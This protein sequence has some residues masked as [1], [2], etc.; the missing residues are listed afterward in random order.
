MLIG[1]FIYQRPPP[2]FMLDKEEVRQRASSQCPPDFLKLALDC[3]A[4]EPKDRPSMKDILA[5]LKVIESEVIARAGPKA[6]EHIGSI[7]IAKKKD[8]GLLRHVGPTWFNTKEPL[9]VIAHVK[10]EEESTDIDEDEEEV[11]KMMLKGVEQGDKTVWRTA[12]WV[13]EPNRPK[14]LDMFTDPG[15]SAG[16]LARCLWRFATQADMSRR[17]QAKRHKVNTYQ[18]TSISLQ[19]PR[20]S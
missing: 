12:R 7:R 8:Q 5:R 16:E 13:E 1:D 2:T 20:P 18:V 4:F 6:D 10:E 9:P 3:T 15:T 19:P 17:Y 11:S 14:L